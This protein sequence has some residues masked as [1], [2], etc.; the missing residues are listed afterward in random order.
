[1]KWITQHIIKVWSIAF[2]HLSSQ[3]GFVSIHI[4]HT[5]FWRLWD[6]FLFS[7]W[8]SRH[9]RRLWSFFWTHHSVCQWWLTIGWGLFSWLPDITGDS[10]SGVVTGGASP[11]TLS[12]FPLVYLLTDS[13]E[14]GAIP[15]H[16][17]NNGCS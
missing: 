9:S 10:D 5:V 12:C 1:M 13:Q 3:I 8:K 4:T 2:I 6:V 11:V 14:L 7:P 16:T 15:D 17:E